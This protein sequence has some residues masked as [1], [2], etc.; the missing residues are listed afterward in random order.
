MGICKYCNRPDAKVTHC[1][2][3]STVI[4]LQALKDQFNAFV[5]YAP[6]EAN[7]ED[8]GVD[9]ADLQP[10]EQPPLDFRNRSSVNTW[11]KTKAEAAACGTSFH[12][13][14][15]TGSQDFIPRRILLPRCMHD[16]T[17]MELHAYIPVAIRLL[18]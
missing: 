10:P 12:K 5:L 17:R 3:A 14:C 11:I 16:C 18:D 4:A 9:A 8:A 6:P 15:V 2:N 13:S 1:I 7:D